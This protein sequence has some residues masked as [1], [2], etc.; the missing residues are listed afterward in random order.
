MNSGTNS[1]TSKRRTTT[2]MT[3]LISGCFFTGTP[4]Q[5]LDAAL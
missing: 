3:M 2:A 1:T 4:L 5:E